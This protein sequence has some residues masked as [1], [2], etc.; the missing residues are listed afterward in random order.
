MRG[1]DPQTVGIGQCPGG[2][3]PEHGSLLVQPGDQALGGGG[4]L[5]A[6]ENAHELIDARVHLQQQLLV[7][8]G[9]AASHDHAAGLAPLLKIEHLADHGV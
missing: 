8:L 3:G 6:A 7:A 2:R 4:N 1:R 9:Q 5:L